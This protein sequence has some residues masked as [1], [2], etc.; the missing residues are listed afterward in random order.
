MTSTC[1]SL[2]MLLLVKEEYRR[3][4]LDT[5]WNNEPRRPSRQ[6]TPNANTH[7]ANLVTTYDS[8]NV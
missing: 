2:P 7:L 6:E 4:G 3:S 5:S 1:I 8:C